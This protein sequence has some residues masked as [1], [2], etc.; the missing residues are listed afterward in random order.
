LILRPEADQD[1]VAAQS[2]YEE[3]HTGLGDEFVSQVSAVFEHIAAMPEMYALA[4]QDVR[5]CRLR[6]FP[7]IAYYRVL[8]DRI[9]VLAVLHGSRDPG[10]WQSRA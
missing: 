9:E 8:P 5:S 3:H 6:R 4:W 7:Y 10:T 1:L 2:W